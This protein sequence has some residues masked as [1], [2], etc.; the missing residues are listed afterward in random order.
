MIRVTR[1]R[2]L[3]A[4]LALFLLGV[5]YIAWTLAGLPP[6]RFYIRES[7]AHP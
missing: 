3:L 7:S 5:G 6:V 4:V 2:V 1:R